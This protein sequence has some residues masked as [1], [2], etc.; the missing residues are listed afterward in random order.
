MKLENK[1]RK[2]VDGPYA[3]YVLLILMLVS[4]FN[5]IDRQIL[6]ILAEDI[7]AD[8]GLSDGD[9]GFLYGTAFAV[10][11]AIFGI[12]LARLADS[13]QRKKLISI[14][15][16]F[17][18]LMTALSGTA[19]GFTSLALCRFGVGMGEASAT[20][21]AYSLLYDYFSPKVRTTVLAI[22]N[23]G[24][25]LGMGIGLFLGGMVL[26]SWNS[27]WP[28]ASLAP[29]A[30]KGWQAAFM[31]VGLPGL[32]LALWVATLKEPPRGLGDGLS[33]NVTPGKSEHPLRI[34][35]DEL[36]PMIPFINLWV[37]RR[38]GAGTKAIGVNVVV[39]SSI[40]LLAT[41]LIHITGETLQWSAL[42]VGLYCAFSWVQSLLCRDPVCYGLIFK[43][44]SLCALYLY[45]GFNVFTAVAIIFWS[46]PYYQRYH[47]VAAAEI[48]SV[49]GLYIA[50]AGLIGVVLGGVLADW[51]RRHT[52]RAKLYI[53]LGAWALSLLS[54]IGLLTAKSLPVAYLGSFVF[55]LAGP[56]ASA[57][58]VSTITDLAI[59]RTR[60][61]VMAMSI[62]ITTF[63]G[64][65]L[66][67]YVVGI[68]SDGF[69]ASGFASGEALQK[70]LMLGLVPHVISVVFLLLALKHI[71]VDED[72]RL[73]RA[74]ALG[75]II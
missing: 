49:M 12:P 58:V 46:I 68:L 42:G 30:L 74:R 75:E 6:S 53:C 64:P 17:W 20:P 59:P 52:R 2:K 18:S 34:L 26:D 8:L 35:K 65:A 66:G 9:L 71:V 4:L 15:L 73:G 19:K 39:G 5:F 48:G 31:V 70:G 25:Y 28:E 60:A 13:W 29:F 11:Y 10:F 69:V 45:V 63:L 67:P 14:G 57:P 27:A 38:V 47:N 3:K 23:G 44:K 54:A 36:L 7:K 1:D 32:L 33:V 22:Y 41:V 50:V 61:V 56:L 55:F 43:C 72:S 51:L 37:M 40:G 24:V 16:G 62:M 21:A